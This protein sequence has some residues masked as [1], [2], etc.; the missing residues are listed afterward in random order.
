MRDIRICDVVMKR[1]AESS[2]LE[3]TFK[4][5]LELAK[6]LD[7]L[8]VSAIE[9]EGVSRPKVDALRIKSIAQLVTRSTLAVPV[10][11]DGHDVDEVW[12]ALEQAVHP[13]LQVQVSTSPARMEY[14]HKLK[15]DGLLDHISCTVKA[16]AALCPD[17]ELIAEDATRTDPAYLK[18]VIQTAIS[19][20]ATTITVSDDAGKM[21][22]CEFAQFVSQLRQDISALEGV[23]LGVACSD[24]LHV[25]NSSATAAL[26]EGADAVKAASYPLD[27]VSL[28]DIV[29]ILAEKGPDIGMR[30]DVDITV[31]K[32]TC[33]QVARICEQG[34]TKASLFQ[35]K[36][37]EDGAHDIQLTAQDGREAVAQGVAALG[38]D[39]SDEDLSL[40][41]ES[42][43]R[44]A[45]KKE[46]VS[47]RE[48][49]AIVAS[50]AMQVPA[51]YTL[52]Q[53]TINSGNKVK[54]T[55]YIKMEAEGKTVERVGMGDG[56]IDAALAAID[57][58]IGV[59]YELEDWQMQ[60]VTEGQEA[61]GEAVIKLR[62]NG[63]VYSGRGLGLL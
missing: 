11:I 23:T 14:V 36:D 25:A 34:V 60:A 3:L 15:A 29:T 50:S 20:G 17:V 21:L 31:L 26:M 13:R 9:I 2:K 42:F 56:P 10:S 18:Q 52:N 30:S 32:R 59:R 61:T 24:A 4:E 38:Y 27:S 46:S 5:K 48:L 55:A 49:D 43:L 35:P 12:A 33:A 7:G 45:S 16:C 51:T 19:A 39:L 62:S 41:Y 63:R 58:I 6:L 8:G 54:A 1:A 57:E 22:P 47:A 53:Y 44:I 40:V 28:P 37:T